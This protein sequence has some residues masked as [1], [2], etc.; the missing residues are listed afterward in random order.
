MVV[1]N[2]DG[3]SRSIRCLCSTLQ[4]S[5]RMLRLLVDSG[6]AED[7]TPAVQAA[8]PGA[9]VLRLESNRGYAAGCNAGS[10]WALARG[11]THLLLLNND[12][13]VGPGAIE[14]LLAGARQHPGAILLY[15]L[16]DFYETFDDDARLVAADMTGVGRTRGI[17]PANRLDHRVVADDPGGVAVADR[18]K[19]QVPAVDG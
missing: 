5:D 6:S 11:A 14:A 10:A 3:V 13:I 7:P 1:V 18:L 9:A 12:V 4:T 17:A 16:G 19:S 8:V 15:R 2:W